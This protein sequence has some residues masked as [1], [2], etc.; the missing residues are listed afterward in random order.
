VSGPRSPTT[1]L[2]RASFPP[3]SE[4]VAAARRQVEAMVRGWLASDSVEV[5]KLLV[6]ELATNA[7]LYA[8]TSFT[9]SATVEGGVV[10]VAVED[11]DPHL[12]ELRQAWP[13][14]ATGRGLQ[15]VERLASRWGSEP[16]TGGKVVWFELMR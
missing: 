13:D 12:P 10:R 2:G 7:V 16:T 6:S 11:G 14:D 8:R 5:A 1:E 4:R 3:Q 15:L 9:L